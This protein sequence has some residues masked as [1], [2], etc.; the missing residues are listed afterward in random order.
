MVDKW[1][2]PVLFVIIVTILAIEMKQIQANMPGRVT[3]SCFEVQA[4]QGFDE[5]GNILSKTEEMCAQ[6]VGRM[7][8]EFLV[9]PDYK[10]V[11][12]K[13]SEVQVLL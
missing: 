13:K 5:D 3:F 8:P 2:M 11:V 7:D 6:S 4:F 10:G 1:V 12:I 9:H